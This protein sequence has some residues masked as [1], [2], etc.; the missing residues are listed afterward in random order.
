L[1]VP[2]APRYRV[3]G[4]PPAL[5]YVD[6]LM[7]YLGSAYYVG[8]LSAAAVHGASHHA[9]QVTQVAVTRPVEGRQVGR[10]RIEFYTRS[11]LGLVPTSPYR[12]YSG[13]VPVSTP[14]ATALDVAADT[15][16]G[17]G[18]DNAASVIVGMMDEAGL[19]ETNLVAIARLFPAAAVRR[20]GWIMERHG[21]AGPLTALREVARAMSATPSKLAP[22]KPGRT[23]L[24]RDWNLYINT[25]L[26]IE[27]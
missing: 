3:L 6:A 1:W 10:G 21:G 17:G 2:V 5:E 19:G 9:A 8:W 18:L 14:E 16:A 15:R 23:S 22:F 7:A 13:D 11:N 25:E 24:D 26:D 20:A 27:T 12:T 4:G